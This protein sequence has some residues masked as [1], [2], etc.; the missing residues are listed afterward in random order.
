[1]G[2]EAELVRSA[3]L[4]RGTNGDMLLPAHLEFL[5]MALVTAT[6]SPWMMLKAEAWKL[7]G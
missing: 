5:L 3:R 4:A 2:L 7:H 6:I 1:M